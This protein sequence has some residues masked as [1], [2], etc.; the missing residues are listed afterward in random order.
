[1]NKDRRTWLKL[2]LTLVSAPVV[3]S[4]KANALSTEMSKIASKKIIVVGAG[5]A[6]LAAARALQQAG[7]T[8]EVL[9]ARD[10]IGGRI[11]TSEHWPDLPLDLGASWIHGVQGNPIRALAK[12]TNASTI[13]T[14]TK[15]ARVFY[16]ADSALQNDDLFES[17]ESMIEAAL[18][19]AR[20]SPTDISIRTAIDQYL[21][22]KRISEPLSQQI[23]FLLNSTLEQ[24][25]S[26]SVEQL[27][28]HYFDEDEL[29]DGADVVFAQGYQ[30][31]VKH[32]AQGLNIR[33][34]QVV[35]TIKY[36]DSGV[37]LT[38][39]TGNDSD[40]SQQFTADA[41]VVTVPLGVLQAQKIAF[42][43]QLPEEKS[44]A[45]QSLGMGVLNKVYLRF[46][47]I[48]WKPKS[49]W[50]E[51]VSKQKG[52]W[53]EWVDF[54]YVAKSPVLLGFNAADYGRAIEQKN[55][56]TII[57]EAMDVVRQML[58]SDI[59]NPI[60]AQITRWAQDEFSLCSYS[61][62]ALNMDEFAR[63][64]FAKPVNNRLFFAGEATHKTY[65]GTAHG[66][67]LSGVNVASQI[68]KQG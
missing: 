54:A 59:P 25:Y 28:A 45:I 20:N 4:T 24:E 42:N 9:E 21:S 47:D 58:G 8:V 37:M 56:D 66:A 40:N 12:Q 31:I 48:F 57:R 33:T 22:N 55:D 27:S 65:F 38:V 3:M 29:F 23:D 26:G 68:L 46:S 10:R 13:T 5:L 53:S 34:Q 49:V 18:K 67:Y 36:N 7:C 50:L 11:H 2:L 17:A 15:S 60:D 61:Y 14:S 44:H 39:A 32:L 64:E 41:V 35:Q 16:A 43:P 1:M 52:Q 63:D 19:Q 30:T 6:G 51:W 62:N